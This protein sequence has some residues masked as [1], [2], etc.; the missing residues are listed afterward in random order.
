MH[1]FVMFGLMDEFEIKSFVNPAIPSG[2]RTGG[3]AALPVLLDQTS[4]ACS[5]V[6][7]VSA[8]F[9]YFLQLFFF[10]QCDSSHCLIQEC[11]KPRK[12]KLFF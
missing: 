3:V 4:G 11:A 10:P 1:T 8:L 6:F 9:S 12:R 7:I 2:N 5:Y